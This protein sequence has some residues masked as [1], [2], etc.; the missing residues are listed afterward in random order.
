MKPF[1][2]TRVRRAALTAS[3]VSGACSLMLATTALGCPE[4]QGTHWSGAYQGKSTSGRWDTIAKEF[5]EV[6][7]G[8]FSFSAL[9]EQEG[10]FE[11]LP[12]TLTTTITDGVLQCG[13]EFFTE[14]ATGEIGGK[15]V[16]E[17]LKDR[18]N[19]TDT[20]VAG[21][22]ENNYGETGT[23]TGEINPAAGSQGIE[24]GST[25]VIPPF[26]TVASM[27]SVAPVTPSE[28]PPDVVAPAGALAFTLEEVPVHGTIDVTLVLP[29]GSAPTAVYKS[30]FGEFEPYPPAKTKIAGNLVTLELTDNELPW[31]ENS[32][33]GVIRD[34]VVPVEAQVGT[35]PTIKKVSP[36]KGTAGMETPV[37]ITGTG[38]TGATAVRFGSTQA[39]DVKVN[40]ATSIT[41]TS[42]KEGAGQVEVTVATHGGVSAPAA[43]DRFTFK[44]AKK[45]KK[46]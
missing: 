22:W 43:K 33:L 36:K 42:P 10:T 24:P 27:F 19:Y 12:E 21:L 20:T 45:Q 44:A 14:A 37:T 26:G 40:S 11:G 2:N 17:T 7:P 34:P 6:E 31:D 29:P 13:E 16:T 35:A 30:A 38:F 23:Y 15:P 41:A 39:T 3:L 46:S 28:L 25:E 5:D 9:G 18:G 1:K 32:T 8:E 4:P